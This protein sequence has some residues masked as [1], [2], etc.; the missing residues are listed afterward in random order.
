ML[1]PEEVFDFEKKERVESESRSI[2]GFIE[3][4]EEDAAFDPAAT[5]EDNIS[6]LDFAAE[7]R[8]TALD[9]LR[10]ARGED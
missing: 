6:S 7:V 9:Y 3:R 4:L 1:P 5:V 8:D 2:D 10:R